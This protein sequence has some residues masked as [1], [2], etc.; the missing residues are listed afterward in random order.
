MIAQQVPQEDLSSMARASRLIRDASESHIWRT[1]NISP[2]GS[3][4][5][6]TGRR[7]RLWTP[8][9]AHWASYNG[10]NTAVVQELVDHLEARPD[11][12]RAVQRLDI[13]IEPYCSALVGKVLDLVHSTVRRLELRCLNSNDPPRDE[14]TV[15]DFNAILSSARPM[16]KLTRLDLVLREQWLERIYLAL[17][18]APHLQELRLYPIRPYGGGWGEYTQFAEQ[19]TENLPPALPRLRYL[20]INGMS[21]HMER[22][23]QG[24]VDASEAL[25]FKLVFTEPNGRWIPSAQFNA[26]AVEQEDKLDLEFE[27]PCD[28]L[29]ETNFFAQD[30]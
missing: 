26:W 14:S 4:S 30:N 9:G 15:D 11:L 24:L 13:Q 29:D 2:D 12:A 25:T 8:I 27:L 21:D 23:V 16:L 6:Y 20:M 28:D 5:E 18:L 3:W 10:F 7:P 17:N 1:L 22:F 19:Q